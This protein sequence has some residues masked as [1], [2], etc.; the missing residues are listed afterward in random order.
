MQ[1]SP[2]RERRDWL[3]EGFLENWLTRISGFSAAARRTRRLI[4]IPST[5]SRLQLQL[6]G[7]PS[8][9][10]LAGARSHSL[11][12]RFNTEVR[13]SRLFRDHSVPQSLSPLSLTCR[14]PRAPSS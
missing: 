2:A 13:L 14:L 8:R 7:E 3:R 6:N 4:A 12:A 5:R 10:P 1:G 9:S 11:S